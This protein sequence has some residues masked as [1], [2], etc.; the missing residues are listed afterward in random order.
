[1]CF[2]AAV[3]TTLGEFGP[4]LWKLQEELVKLYAAKLVREGP[5]LDGYTGK[6]LTAAFRTDLKN[7]LQVAVA[8]GMADMLPGAGLV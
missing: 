5:R 7:S 8:K 3:C 6:Q 2:R 1:M 4:D